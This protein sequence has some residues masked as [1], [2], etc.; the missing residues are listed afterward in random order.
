MPAW[1]TKLTE[2][3]GILTELYPERD[4]GRMVVDVTGIPASAIAFSDKARQNWHNI[5]R[6]ANKRGKVRD[7]VQLA[8]QE[9]PEREELPRLFTEVEATEPLTSARSLNGLLAREGGI[10][11]PELPRPG[12]A[13]DVSEILREVLRGR[14][15][16]LDT[17]TRGTSPPRTPPAYDIL[18]PGRRGLQKIVKS[19]NLIDIIAWVQGAMEQS[20]TVCKIETAAG[21]KGTGFLLKGQLLMTNNHVIPDVATAASTRLVFNYKTDKD[22]NVLE[23]THYRLDP[24]GFFVTSAEDE[25]DY[26]IVRIVDDGRTPLAGWGHVQLE[27]FF[28]PNVDEKVTVIQ[29]PG[30][31][32]MKMALPDDI[33]SVW[34]RYL[35]YTTDT[36]EGS[37]GAPVFNKHWKVVALHHAGKNEQSYEGGLQIDAAGT[38]AP[39]NRG[40]LIKHILADLQQRQFSLPQ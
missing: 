5:L 6:E 9:Y 36:R 4:D 29:H 30:G 22:N 18:V 39:S 10:T 35:F 31:N 19:D 1:N 13:G 34:G 28:D 17:G 8:I 7:I 12:A 14:L 11:V 33:I 16:H 23:Q 25:L 27:D 3:R 38:I 26:T 21:E 15:H 40:I 32:Y 24:T 2:L 20:R 37:S